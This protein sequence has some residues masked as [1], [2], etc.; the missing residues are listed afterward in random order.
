MRVVIIGTTGR[1]GQQVTEQA[2]TRGHSVTAIVRKPSP[3]RKGGLQAIVADPRKT[4]A[5]TLAL[6]EQDAVIS[7]LGQ[8]AGGNPWLVRDAAAAT[9]QAMQQT[10]VKRFVVVSGALLYPTFNPVALLLRRLMADKL[11]DGRAAEHVITQSDTD[12][13]IVRPPRLLDGT[14]SKGYRLVTGQKPNLTW[15]LQFRDLAACLLDLSEGKS[16]I[17]EIVGV[18]SL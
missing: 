12:W 8:R 3:E 7:C 14:E 1:T 16:H 9:I 18:A 15:S 2:L 4:E 13:T 5:L 17:G 10:G 11:T 6:S